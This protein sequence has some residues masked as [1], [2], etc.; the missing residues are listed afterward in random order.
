MNV[1][2]KMI[3]NCVIR[4]GPQLQI[5]HDGEIKTQFD[6]DCVNWVVLYYMFTEGFMDGQECAIEEIF[7]F[8]KF[9][10]QIER[11]ELVA[12]EEEAV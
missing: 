7:I 5:F 1:S 4:N 11:E 10:R 3:K 8:D 12:D 9:D 2:F 6:Y